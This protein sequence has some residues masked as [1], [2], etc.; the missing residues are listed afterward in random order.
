MILLRVFYIV[1]H[2]NINMSQHNGIDYTKIDTTSV[3]SL[4]LE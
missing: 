1:V 2:T 4:Q 3:N